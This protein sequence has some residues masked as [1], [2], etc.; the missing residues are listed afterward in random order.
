MLN[1][2]NSNDPSY[3]YKMP[4]A[5]VKY[6][7]GGNGKH[8]LITNINEIAQAINSPPM[9]VC[10]YIS[11]FYS[12][13]Y[14]EKENS[15]NGFH[16]NIQ[17][18]IFNYINNF[19]ICKT[20]NIPE[21]NYYLEKVSAKK[22]NL[23]CKCSACGTINKPNNNN[24]INTKCI[25]VIIKYLTKENNWINTDGSMVQQSVII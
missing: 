19:V 6:V 22:S 11:I 3:R 14:N 16:H 20:C 10:K 18:V 1:V 7:G 25:D 23:I 8:T 21:L 15:I 5:S 13:A 2:N 12:V 24:K 17:D 9:I 4:I